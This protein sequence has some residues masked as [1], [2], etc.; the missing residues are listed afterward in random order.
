MESVSTN[1]IMDLLMVTLISR[2]CE[3]MATIEVDVLSQYP[4]VHNSHEFIVYTSKCS[5]VC[6][7][8]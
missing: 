6:I 7:Y 4:D 2:Y 3:P 8:V 5:Y 1:I